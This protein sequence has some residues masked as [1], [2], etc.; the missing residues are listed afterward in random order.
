MLQSSPLPRSLLSV[1]PPRTLILV[2]ERLHPARP[3]L[4]FTHIPDLS[5]LSQTHPFQPSLIRY[6]PTSFVVP[7][8]KVSLQRFIRILC[9][10]QLNLQ[11]LLRKDISNASSSSLASKGEREGERDSPNDDSRH[12]STQQ[13]RIPTHFQSFSTHESTQKTRTS[14]RRNT[15]SPSHSQSI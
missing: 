7:I 12:D 5:P 8:R 13:T 6:E 9:F 4:A 10:L 14:T 3:S 15:C 2:L 11:T 1:I